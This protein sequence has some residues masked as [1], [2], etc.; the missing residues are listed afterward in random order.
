[1]KNPNLTDVQWS[2]LD[3]RLR[4]FIRGRV[5]HDADI[6]DILQDSY[7]AMQQGIDR[8][9]N[10][11]R[12]E[13]WLYKIVRHKIIDYYRRNKNQTA[14]E[15]EMTDGDELTDNL[16]NE[17]MPCLDSMVQTLEAQ[18]QVVIRS[19][20]L[21]EN[22]LQEYADMKGVSLSAAKSRVLRAR[23]RLRTVFEECCT[24]HYNSQENLVDVRQR[25]CD[26]C[27][28]DACE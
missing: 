12:F 8:L 14:D 17:L 15:L 23:K 16:I 7:Q 25:N 26:N 19:V 4:N 6:D 9:Q 18:D 27:V 10:S 21:E 22:S 20:H 5:A 13:S 3:Q 1:M 24:F 11:E 28:D 2:E